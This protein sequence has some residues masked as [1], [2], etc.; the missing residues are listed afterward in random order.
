M[1]AMGLFEQ[2]EAL[3]LLSQ[4]LRPKDTAA[5]TTGAAPVQPAVKPVP[6]P[7]TPVRTG[8]MRTEPAAPD[9]DALSLDDF[10]EATG[11]STR[12]RS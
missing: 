1:L 9:P 12:R 2:T 10:A 7:P 6:R 3:S 4:R 8:P 11:F 5:V